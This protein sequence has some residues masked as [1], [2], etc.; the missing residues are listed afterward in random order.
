MLTPQ[1]IAGQK[2]AVQSRQTARQPSA[3]YG[4]DASVRCFMIA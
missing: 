3:N 2:S 4:S 1:A